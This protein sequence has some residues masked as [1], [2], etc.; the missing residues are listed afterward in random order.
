[1]A[2]QIEV[3]RALA[4]TLARI[5]A[6][7]LDPSLITT[8]GGTGEVPLPTPAPNEAPPTAGTGAAITARATARADSLSRAEAQRALAALERRSALAG[9]AARSVTGA[10]R[11]DGDTVRGVLTLEGT[12]PAVRVT[13]VTASSPTPVGLSGMAVSEL[14]RLEGLETEVRGVRVGPREVAV[15]SFTVHAIDGIPVADGV[16]DNQGGVW[17]VRQSDGRRRTLGRVP[18][19]LQA[20]VG[21]RVWVALAPGA[22]PSYG[23]ITRR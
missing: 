21:A 20:F 17:S 4:D 7:E 8:L 2:R 16:L 18:T 13:L 15:T 23:V 14:M 6:G 12:P 10:R 3:G 5:T 22:S 11:A 9:T 19:P 1:M